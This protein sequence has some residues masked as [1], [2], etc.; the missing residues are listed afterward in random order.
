[1][2]DNLRYIVFLI[3]SKFK[4]HDGKI[5]SS[6]ADAHEYACDAINENYSDKFVI[7]MFNFDKDVKDLLI[8]GIETFGFKGDKK[9]V[10]QTALFIN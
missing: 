3:D 7:G 2:N 9:N 8:S 4:E 5:F 1:M 10:N 6:Y